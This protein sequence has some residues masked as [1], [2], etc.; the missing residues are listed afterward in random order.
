MC[1]WGWKGAQNIR[2]L[3]ALPEDP[4]VGPSIHIGGLTTACNSSSRE[5]DPSFGLSSKAPNM[6]TPPSTNKK[7]L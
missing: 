2:G 7:N 4:N 6:C 3:A 5:S 1:V